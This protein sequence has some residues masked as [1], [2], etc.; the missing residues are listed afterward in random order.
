[1]SVAVIFEAKV[2]KG[3]ADAFIALLA[4]A[5]PV[6]RQKEGCRSVTVYQDAEDPDTVVMLEEWDSADNHRKYLEW[7]QQQGDSDRAGEFYDRPPRLTYLN[8]VDA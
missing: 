5:L 6:T 1:M 7:R 3:K 4:Q 2:E 8:G